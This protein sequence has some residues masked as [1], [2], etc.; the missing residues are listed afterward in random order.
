MTAA[1]D[2]RQLAALDVR[3]LL[4]CGLHQVTTCSDETMMPRNIIHQVLFC[5][6]QFCNNMHAMGDY[7]QGSCTEAQLK[8]SCSSASITNIQGST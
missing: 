8:T 7:Q 5:V 3:Q 1:L 4:R 2:G 6:Y